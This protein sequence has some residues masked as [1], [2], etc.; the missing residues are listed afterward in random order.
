MSTSKGENLSTILSFLKNDKPELIKKFVKENYNYSHCPT[1]DLWFDKN[2]FG[3]ING[4]ESHSIP[5]LK[6]FDKHQSGQFYVCLEKKDTD[7]NHN[8]SCQNCRMVVSSDHLVV[9]KNGCVWVFN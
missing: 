6:L 2:E 9:D 4:C 5:C 7:H 1:C 3:E 8:S